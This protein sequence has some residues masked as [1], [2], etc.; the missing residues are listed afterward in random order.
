MTGNISRIRARTKGIMLVMAVAIASHAG[1]V[2]V[3]SMSTTDLK[4]RRA[5]IERKI[6]DDDFGGGWWGLNRWISHGTEKNKAL[7]EKEAIDA[8]LER[9]KHAN[10]ESTTGRSERPETAGSADV[11]KL[12]VVDYF[13]RLPEIFEGSPAL[14]L[15]TMKEPKSGVI[16]EANGYLSCP[17]DAVQPP[18]EVA[19][20]RFRDGSPLL[21]VAQGDHGEKGKEDAREGLVFLD[22]FRSGTDPTKMHKVDRSIFPIADAGDRKGDWR[23][24]LPKYGRTVLVFSQDTGVVVHALTWN[25]EKFVEVK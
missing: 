13:L 23:F 19:L 16:D 24:E 9:R 21:A 8:E 25:G 7:K 1:A 17:G 5:E 18:F 20:F 6:A 2:D 11:E 4:K 14:W 15:T 12:T 10:R 22:F 3:Q